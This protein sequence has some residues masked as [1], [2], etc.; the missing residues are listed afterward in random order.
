MALPDGLEELDLKVYVDYPQER[1]N[2]LGPYV[3]ATDGTQVDSGTAQSCMI[4]PCTLS[5]FGMPLPRT[6]EWND[7]TTPCTGNYYRY[8]ISDFTFTG[9]GG[10]A[11]WT[12]N[13]YKKTGNTYIVCKSSSDAVMSQVIQ[14]TAGVK[15]NEP[16]FFSFSKLEKK[17]SNDEP[18]IK[19]YWSNSSNNDKDIQ[20]HFSSDGSCRV[21]RGYLP[22]TGVI[23][24]LTSSATVTGNGTRFL[25]ST[26][27]INPGTI[28]YD[29]YGRTLGTVSTIASNTSLTLTANANKQVTN[30]SFNRKQPNN[31]QT[32]SRTESN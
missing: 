10:A 25:D 19:L 31:V 30:V 29:V 16:L 3:F 20:L 8:Q 14:L 13:D 22:L 24:T 32:Y 1:K 4:D 17:N 27:G 23:S 9:T 7:A 21:Y 6:K 15:R 11:N 2:R 5:V 28:L 12:K 26:Q 18:L